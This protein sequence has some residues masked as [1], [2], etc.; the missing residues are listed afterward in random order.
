MHLLLNLYTLAIGVILIN[1]EPLEKNLQ[2][3]SVKM[4]DSSEDTIASSYKRGPGAQRNDPIPLVSFAIKARSHGYC[5]RR[6]SSMGWSRIFFLWIKK[7]YH[8]NC[9]DKQYEATMPK[10]KEIS[11]WMLLECKTSFRGTGCLLPWAY[12]KFEWA[13]TFKA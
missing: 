11:Q 2:S 3:G 9:G 4:R 6:L 5:L 1:C 13:V 7:K 8:A 10:E 12:L